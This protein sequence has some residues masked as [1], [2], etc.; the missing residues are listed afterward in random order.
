MTELKANRLILT[1][2][3]TGNTF[4]VC[5]TAPFT[6]VGIIACLA[7]TQIFAAWV[8]LGQKCVLDCGLTQACFDVYVDVVF[9]RAVLLL[10]QPYISFGHVRTVPR[11]SIFPS[12][13]RLSGFEQ[14]EASSKF[15]TKNIIEIP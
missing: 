6:L 8:N 1:N 9:G 12:T 11:A 15:K 13:A 4:D 14:H 7:S 10:R 2:F 5:F 3:F